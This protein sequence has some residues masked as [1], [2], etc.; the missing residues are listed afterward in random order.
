MAPRIPEA[1][2]K[3]PKSAIVIPDKNDYKIGRKIPGSN[4]KI[5]GT[6]HVPGKGW[7]LTTDYYAH[8]REELKADGEDQQTPKNEECQKLIPA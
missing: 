4:K 6:V 1:P 2:Y 8:V 3:K 5:E 7:V